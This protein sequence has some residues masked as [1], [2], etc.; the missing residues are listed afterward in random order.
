VATATSQ[1]SVEEYLKMVTEPDCD[2]V[3]G[4]V[5]ERHVGER[6]HAA[7]QEALIGWFRDHKHEQNIFVF[8][9]L[10]IQVAPERFR[11]PDVTILSRE[12]PREQIITHPPLA[13][14]EI[15]SPEDTMTRMLEKLA[16]Y[17]RMGIRAIW[18]VEPKKPSYFR[19]VEGKLIPATVFDLPDRS[20]SVPM[21]EIQKLID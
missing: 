15:L 17:E 13:V 4:V 7:W 11:V 16:D 6:D 18:V 10:R 5:E 19:F 3:E 8:P 1:I 14:F 9:E 21:V 12:A 20:F 2:Y